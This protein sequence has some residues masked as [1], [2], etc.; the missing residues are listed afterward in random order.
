MDY[1]RPRRPS[2]TS[3]S[4]SSYQD[5][6]WTPPRPPRRPVS[7]WR[8]DN[9][10]Q[11]VWPNDKHRGIWGR[12]KDIFTNKGPDIF[13]AEQNT[14]EP[15]RPIWSNWKT[16]GHQHP[17]DGSRRWGD[18]GKPFRQDEELPGVFGFQHRHLDSK[19]DFA[20]RRYCMPNAQVWSGVGWTNTKPYRP[21]WVRDARGEI[22]HIGR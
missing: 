17:D 22:H 11:F 3:S 10:W 15:E 2:P 12:W 13:I 7:S 16:R 6:I 9:R 8:Q 21:I 20:T 18:Y 5:T 14:R 4:D 19:Y 1:S